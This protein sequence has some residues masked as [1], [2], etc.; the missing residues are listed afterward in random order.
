[1]KLNVNQV[2]RLFA[3]RGEGLD[4]LLATSTCE[5]FDINYLLEKADKECLE[6]WNT[7]HLGEVNFG[8]RKKL[9]EAIARRYKAI[10]PENIVEASPEE[11]VLIALSTMLSPGDEVIVMEPTMPSLHE[12]PRAIG[13]EVIPWTLN[14]TEWGW[15]IDTDFLKNTISPKTKLLI[16]NFPNN[17]TGC[18][19]PIGELQRIAQIAD[20]VGCWIF[21]EET[22]R[23]MEHDP[24]ATTPRMCD[25]YN[26]AVSL[27]SMCRNG[28]AALGLGWLATQ[29][30]TLISDF[31][32]Y[33]DYTSPSTN[34]MSEVLGLIYFRNIQSITLRN[35]EIIEHNLHLVEGY[36]ESR[37]EIFEWTPPDAGSTAFP[38]M[39][40]A[41]S[42]N[43]LCTHAMKDIG[44]LLVPDR[45][46]SVNMNRFRIGYGRRDFGVSLVKFSDFVDKYVAQ[47]GKS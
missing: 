41:Y 42:S 11:G 46:Y 38:K 1:M 22:L 47:V 40:S 27:G 36:F 18:M 35:K 5:G 21:N 29:N 24:G 17:P 26:R 16:L 12:I 34:P 13:C 33:K 6:M 23:G 2:E 3:S 28:F 4:Y 7:L 32:A 39:N 15:K 9:R 44:M 20:S 10:E 37:K 45:L 30:D 8:V 25:I 19:P 43:D 14:P 31:L